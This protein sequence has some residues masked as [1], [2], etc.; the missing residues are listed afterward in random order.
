MSNLNRAIVVS[1]LFLIIIIIIDKAI[2]MICKDKKIETKRKV[3]LLYI[4]RIIELI[5]FV[6]YVIYSFF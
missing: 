3:I 5:I 1:I 4:T 2:N 6:C